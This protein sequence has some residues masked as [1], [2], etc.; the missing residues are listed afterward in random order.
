[1]EANIRQKLAEN[2]WKGEIAFIIESRE[3]E[4]VIA[5]MPVTEAAKNPFG[6]MHA[7]ALIWFADIAATLCAIGDLESIGEDGSGFPLA[8]NL[9]TVL[10]G[11]ENAGDLI[12]ISKTDRRGGKLIVIRTDVRGDTGRLLIDMTTTHLRAG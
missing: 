10:S 4:R 5:R 6:T 7:G 8:V 2:K 3:P 11:N 12:A 9:H 1:M